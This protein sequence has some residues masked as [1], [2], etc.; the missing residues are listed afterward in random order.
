[1]LTFAVRLRGTESANDDF[2]VL[3]LSFDLLRVT[4][5]IPDSLPYVCS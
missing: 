5:S 3:N 1:M 4:H 2:Q